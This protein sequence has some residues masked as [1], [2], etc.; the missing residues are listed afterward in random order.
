MTDVSH[1]MFDLS[2]FLQG[3][4][5]LGS[6]E[7]SVS[8]VEL[9]GDTD[10]V[11]GVRQVLL[12]GVP[13]LDVADIDGWQLGAKGVRRLEKAKMPTYMEVDDLLTIFFNNHIK[14]QTM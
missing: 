3:D 11:H 14:F 5:N 8:G 12:R 7:S 4:V 10:S 9:P 6:V 13:H 2:L 1:S